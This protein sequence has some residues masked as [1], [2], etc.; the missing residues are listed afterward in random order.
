[1]LGVGAGGHHSKEG[2]KERKERCIWKRMGVKVETHLGC[3]SCCSSC[4]FAFKV[5]I[6]KKAKSQLNLSSQ[7]D[8]RTLY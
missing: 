3:L 6:N 1:M 5:E 7:T 4:I 8:G 2:Q